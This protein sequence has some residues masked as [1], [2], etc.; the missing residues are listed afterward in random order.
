MPHHPSSA[1]LFAERTAFAS[2]VFASL[3]IVC[4]VLGYI[5]LGSPAKSLLVFL[6]L[7]NTCVLA[8][9]ALALPT[10]LALHRMLRTDAPLLSLS[11]VIVLV[12]GIVALALSGTPDE[13]DLM[14][15]RLRLYLTVASMVFIVSWVFLTSAIGR[16]RNAVP[17]GWPATVLAAFYVGYPF[18]IYGVGKRLR[19]VVA[20]P[21]APSPPAASL[22]A[23]LAV[24]SALCWIW[25]G[26]F[27]VSAIAF[28]PPTV[29]VPGRRGW[30][31]LVTVLSAVV[32]FI[33]C[34][35][36]HLIRKRRALGGWLGLITTGFWTLTLL[37]GLLARNLTVSAA[38]PLVGMLAML[39]NLAIFML[40]VANWGQ[41][42]ASKG[43]TRA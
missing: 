4:L 31:A 18:W 3:G 1:I 8:Q 30:I 16:R 14:S 12:A 13:L 29:F 24:A 15:L 34:A 23:G 35:A 22:P 26:V 21:A 7:N 38:T 41:L 9:Y 32:A 25:G 42:R 33:Y 40:L 6:T 2:A 27:G 17:T 5:G 43:Q 28:I 39:M 19:T 36:G 37:P 20:T 11:S 10:V